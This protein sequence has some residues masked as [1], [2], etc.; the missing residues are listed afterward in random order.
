MRPGNSERNP[1]FPGRKPME[2]L[3]NNCAAPMV[4]CEPHLGKPRKRC[5]IL[6]KG[7]RSFLSLSFLLSTELKGREMYLFADFGFCVFNSH[8]AS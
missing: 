5:R 3:Q 7:V 6:S 1:E 4:V 8:M 2:R